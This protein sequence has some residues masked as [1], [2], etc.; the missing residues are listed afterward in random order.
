MGCRLVGGNSKS[1]QE[2]WH[3]MLGRK[4]TSGSTRL[5]KRNGGEAAES[6]GYGGMANGKSKTVIQP[7]S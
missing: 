4:R 2:G 6:M 7:T 3:A 5:G 1:V